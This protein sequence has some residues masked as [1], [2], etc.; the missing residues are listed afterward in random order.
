MKGLR[1]KIFNLILIL[2]FIFL[3]SSASA[4][5]FDVLNF[6]DDGIDNA[7]I[8]SLSQDSLGYLWIGT[9]DGL[10]RFNGRTFKTYTTADSLADNFVSCSFRDGFYMWFGHING[11]VSLFQNGTFSR[12]PVNIDDSGPVTSIAS[13]AD[14]SVWMST[15]NG[16]FLKLDPVTG[17][18]D[19]KVFKTKDAVQTFQFVENN[20]LLIGTASGLFICIM[21]ASEKIVIDY[22][23]PE[24]RNK[25]IVRILKKVSGDGYY[26][27][28]AVDGIFILNSDLKTKHVI[29][30]VTNIQNISEDPHQNLWVATFGR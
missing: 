2:V 17:I 12:L 5:D 20:R 19:K 8:Y 3:C 6:E 27:A 16:Y 25:Q 28:S 11:M 9:G 21:D 1:Q 15:Y 24:T 26:V 29:T 30:G 18:T 10:I 22:E 23:I 13:E 14:G 4:Q 7:Y